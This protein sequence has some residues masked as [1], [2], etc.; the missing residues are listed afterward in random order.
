AKTP[1]ETISDL[2]GWFTAAMQVPDVRAKLSAIGLFPT[3]M[4]GADFAAFIRRQYVEY[5]RVIREVHFKAQLYAHPPP[6][7][8][9]I[10]RFDLSS[11]SLLTLLTAACARMFAW[12]QHP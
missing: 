7:S 9:C 8:H 5:G 1:K 6:M 12:A 11:E 10:H 2:A 3:E 4:C